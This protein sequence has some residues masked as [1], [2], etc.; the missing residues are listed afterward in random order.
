MLNIQ[1]LHDQGVA[2]ITPE[3]KLEASDFERVAQ[4]IDPFIKKHGTL[5]GLMIYAASFPG[6]E[7]FAALVGHIR[8][9]KDHHRN[10]RRV[11]AVSDNELLKIAPMIAKHFVSAEIRHFPFSERANA[12]AWLASAE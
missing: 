8:F 2:V 3:G 5:N 10:I 9:I 7:D 4:D 1:L 12:L 11:A 6:W